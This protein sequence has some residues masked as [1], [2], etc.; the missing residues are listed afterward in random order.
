MLNRVMMLW[1]YL[2]I[3]AGITCSRADHPPLSLQPGEHVVFVGNGLAA[4]MQHQ[5]HLETA[6]HQR[7][8]SH[9]LVVRNMADAGNTPGFRPHSG[10]PNPYRF[11]GAETFRK[12]LNQ[13]KDRWGS[14]HAGFGTYP[15]TD[16]WL[17]RLKADVIIGFFGYNES[18]DGEEGVENFKAELAGWIRHMRSSTYHEGQS[19]RVA[20]VSPI[21]FEDL[22][23]THHTPNGRSINERLALYTRA[24]EGIATAERVPFV[25]V[26]AS[27]QRWFTS[28][29]SALTL[30]GF[31]LNE[32]GNRLLAHQVAETLFGAQ[33]PHNRDMEG[34]REAVM[35]KNW[36]WHH[37]A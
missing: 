18:F 13:A 7:F 2:A 17:D 29:D 31:Q 10:R 33:A 16:Q 4:R 27:S 20:L 8:P 22:S 21:A 14:G 12:P 11:P 9:R 35:E 34:V 30:D 15:T 6:I 23:A 1:I 5:G 26:F 32:K 25:D 24:M 3:L 37:W 28:S 19:P 36:M